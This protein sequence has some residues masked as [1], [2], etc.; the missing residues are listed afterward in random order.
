MK[1]ALTIITAMLLC[2]CSK[3]VDYVL[4]QNPT[5]I[6]R[7]PLTVP[8]RDWLESGC[9]FKSENGH[10]VKVCHENTNSK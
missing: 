3:T 4:P 8:H 2:G 9:W 7:K 10:D 6:E 5:A 1:Y